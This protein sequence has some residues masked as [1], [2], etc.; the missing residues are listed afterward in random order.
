MPKLNQFDETF[1]LVNSV[2]DQNR[3]VQ[4][5]AYAG[6]F[7]GD[8]THAGKTGEQIYMVEQRVAKAGGCASVILGV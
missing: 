3:A 5:F 1:A 8:A 2:I 7:P 4:Q 6:A